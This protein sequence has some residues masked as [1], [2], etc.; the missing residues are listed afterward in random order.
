MRFCRKSDPES[1]GKIENVIKYIKY[2]FLRGRKYYGGTVLNDQAIA[3][4]GRTGNAKVH[5]TTLKIPA[6]E[7]EL[8]KGHLIPLKQPFAIARDNPSY[9]VTKDNVIHFKGSSYSVLDGTFHKP[10]TEVIV[11]QQNDYLLICNIAGEEI[12]RHVISLLK[13]Q[14][15]R[16]NNHRRDHS[17]KV[18][19]LIAQVTGLFTGRI[20][21]QGTSKIY[22]SKCPVM[23]VTKLTWLHQQGKNT[24]KKKWTKP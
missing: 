5:S 23:L 10:K 7:W 18:K 13:G 3:W 17:K 22:T 19:E 24:R 6:L 12:A 4:L 16:N 14:Q 15:V 1:K 21:P 11:R 9:N 8:E 20:K 2:N